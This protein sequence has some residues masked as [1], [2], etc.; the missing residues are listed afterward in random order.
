M[1]KE[2][3]ERFTLFPKQTVFRSLTKK[4]AI[5]SKTDEQIPNPVGKKA[6]RQNNLS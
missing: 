6:S 2:Q 5:C 3:Q 1:T 4:L